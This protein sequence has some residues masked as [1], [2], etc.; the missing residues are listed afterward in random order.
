MMVTASQLPETQPQQLPT[1]ASNTG[2]PEELPGLSQWALMRRRFNRH[3]LAR[4][5]GAIV[6][7][8]YL[9]AL[10]ADFL[11][12]SD[13]ERSN[14]VRASVPPQPVHLFSDGAFKPHVHGLTR[15]RDPDTLA[16]VYA[17]DIDTEI[18]LTLFA[19]GFRYRLLG[20]VTTDIHLLGTAGRA[21]E[22]NLYLLGSDNLG[23]DLYSRLLL[24]IR[25]SLLVGMA[26]VAVSLLVG[27]SMGMLSGYFG[28]MIDL[29]VQRLIEILRAIPTIPLWMGLAAAIPPSWSITAVYL[30]ITLIIA[31]IGWTELAREIRGRV[32]AL[33]DEEYVIAARLCGAGHGR[34][35]FVHLLPSTTSHI[36]A[37]TS[38]AIPIMIASETALGFLGLGLRP[39]AIS[40]GVLLKDAQ[41][42]QNIA[43]YPWLLLPIVP[44]TLII[45]A[46]NFLGDGLRDAADPHG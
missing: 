21:T 32:I 27:V 46:F 42:L 12:Y 35:M 22:G 4:V 25:T 43:L 26:A 1:A 39:P 6:L 8:F 5:S 38:L 33:G 31:L 24:G 14:A 7:L 19:H 18:P 15:S 17:R 28:G 34:I 2:V 36:I 40:L 16:L 45:L 29:L 41:V 20:I 13:P 11:A 30:A 37:A 44:T 10:L 3:K 9:I 23:R